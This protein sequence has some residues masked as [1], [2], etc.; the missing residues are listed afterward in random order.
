MEKSQQHH[1]RGRRRHHGHHHHHHHHQHHHHQ[2]RKKREAQLSRASS[3]KREKQCKSRR[4]RRRRRRRLQQ[5]QHQQQILSL[6]AL[7]LYS[8]SKKVHIMSTSAPFV[9]RQRCTTI[10]KSRI[11]RPDCRFQELYLH[12]KTRFSTSR[13]TSRKEDERC[14]LWR[15]STKRI[16]KCIRA[17]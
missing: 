15:I 8:N 5:Q 9:S 11:T 3:R 10:L 13:T 2:Y 14:L 1:C 7:A 16:H 12:I 6:Q 4:R 17:S